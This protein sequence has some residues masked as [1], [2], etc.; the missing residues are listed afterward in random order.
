MNSSGGEDLS[1]FWRG[2]YFNNY[3][4]DM[5]I[6]KAT[7]DP[8]KGVQVAVANLG[9]LVLPATLRV[10]LKDGTHT[11]I[12]IPAETWLLNTTHTFT[13]PTPTPATSVTLDPDHTLP[14]LNRT[15]NTLTLN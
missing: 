11:D 6:T 7:A 9:Q 15:N 8:T 13:I 12:T 14:D 2:W 3:Q 1:Y 4:L 10:T 5:A